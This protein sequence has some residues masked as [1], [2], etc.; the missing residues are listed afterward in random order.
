MLAVARQRKD[1]KEVE[2]VANS[3]ADR[4][5]SHWWKGVI[6]LDGETAYDDCHKPTKPSIGNPKQSYQQQLEAKI[7]A[8]R[9]EGILLGIPTLCDRLHLTTFEKNVVLM[10]LAPEVNQRYTRL[11]S[12]LQSDEANSR[13]NLPSVDLVLR[14]LCR[15]DVEWRS[16]RTNLSSGCS[17]M[18]HNL[19]KLV[20]EDTFLSG[21]LKLAAPLVDYL[22]SDTPD[23]QDLELLLRQSEAPP[24]KTPVFL[25]NGTPTVGWENL[26]LPESLTNSL[27]Y[28]CHRVQVQAQPGVAKLLG[29][30]VAEQVT[31]L[32]TIVLLAGAA[33]TGKTTAA[34]AIAQTLQTSLT[35][36]DLALV[37]PADYSCLLQEITN[38]SPT[39]LLLKSAQFWFGRSSSLPASTAHQFLE[40]RRQIAGMTLLSV[41]LRQTIKL[42]WQ[43]QT[44]QVLEFPLPRRSDRFHLWRQAFSPEV[45]LDADIDWDLLARQ[46][47]LTG[48]EIR[49]IAHEATLHAIDPKVEQLKL[50]MHHLI[51]ALAQRGMKLKP[52]SQQDKPKKNK[53][54]SP[55]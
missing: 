1:T 39:V 22:L 43:R 10:V 32:G 40:Q 8:S 54:R 37:H 38:Q 24:L 27:R 42:Q 13:S 53:R 50:T 49:T 31:Q 36:V 19:L 7:Q 30:V 9:Q 4:V 14:L 15:N 2:R 45:D 3:R 44:D 47:P 17:L 34:A 25:H 16:A 18:Q 21:R 41:G 33:G 55:T 26:I 46:L 35:S 52:K 11:Y 6:T 20:A 29:N 12:Y 28:L 51:Y 23:P 48:G 5:T